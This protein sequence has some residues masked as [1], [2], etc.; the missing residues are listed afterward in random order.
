MTTPAPPAAQTDAALRERF[1][2][3]VDASLRPTMA[4]RWERHGQ[5]L[6]DTLRALYAAHAYGGAAVS[7][8]LAEAAAAANARP[9]ALRAQDAARADDP[10]WFLGPDMI[11]YSAYVDRFAGTLQGVAARVD[12]LRALGVRY[13]HLLP[14]QRARDGESDGGFAVRDYD[15]IEPALGTLDDLRALTF[16]LRE[17]GISLCAD[18]V[19]NH[20]SDDHRWALAARAG[21]RRYADY[22]LAFE[23]RAIPD[24][25]EATLGQ[26]F[27][28]TAP[29]NFTHVDGLGWVWTTFYP[30]QWDLN[31]ANPRVFVDMALTLLRMA[32]R[33]IE[34]FRLDSTAYLWKREGTASL[35]QPEA[36]AILQALHALC[37]LVAPGVLLKA[38]A[39]VP[40]RELPPYFGSGEAT[41]RECHL[42]YHST[43]MAAAWAALAEQRGDVLRHVVE[44]TP[45][46]PPGCAWITYVRCHDDIGWGVLAAEAAGDAGRA[47][48]DLGRVSRFYAGETESSYARGRAFQSDASHAHGSNGMTSA[49][50]GIESALA[51]G[52]TH[53]LALA[54]RRLVL[55]HG[56]ALACAGVPLLYM[57]DELALGNDTAF[58]RGAD[59]GDEGRWLHRPKMDWRLVEG[60]QAGAQAG[61]AM[62]ANAALR[63]LIEARRR[64]PALAADAPMQALALD[65]AALFGLRRGED[66]VALFNL[67]G[68]V[69]RL[70]RLPMAAPTSWRD[71]IE[72]GDPLAFPLLIEPYAM[73]WLVA[74]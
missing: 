33:G 59:S 67:S 5:R 39:I 10:A 21:D 9:L 46:L 4:L 47:P 19:L 55:L 40:T 44:Q 2:A 7:E 71:A 42:A 15:A 26:V 34:A 49:L 1:L 48:F 70:E 35:N 60:A 25:H 52:D 3:A 24:R 11:G 63:E 50:V 53:A 74:A 36:H 69:Q 58:G 17:A 43:L 27:P 30:Y 65:E 31:W 51:A 32:N 57:G 6:L 61:V 13:L 54:E 23:D 41:G 28:Q 29:G 18:F 72:G 56:I 73:R 62:R 45:P 37:G 14:F 12:Y 66:F 68:Q 16:R 64:T 22:Y 8:L 38:E 20:T